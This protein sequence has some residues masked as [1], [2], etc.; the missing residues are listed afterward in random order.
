LIGQAKLLVFA[1]EQV[2]IPVSFIFLGIDPLEAAKQKLSA[3]QKQIASTIF[4]HLFI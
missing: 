2:V 4:K 3:Q 1:S